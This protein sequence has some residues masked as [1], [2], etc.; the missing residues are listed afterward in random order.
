MIFGLSD[1]SDKSD[2][3]DFVLVAPLLR[4]NAMVRHA[5]PEKAVAT[6]T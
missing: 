4:S 1:M 2:K 6:W 5:A 3:S